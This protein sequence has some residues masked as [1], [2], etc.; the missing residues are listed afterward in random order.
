MMLLFVITKLNLGELTPTTLYL[1]M[2]DHSLTYPQGILE[3]VH[4]KVDKFIFSVDFV[5]LEMEE[6]RE[7]LIILGMPFLATRQAL[8]N[9]KNGELTLRVGEEEVKFNL[10]KTVRFVNDDKKTCMRVDSLNPSIG[11]VLRDMVKWNALEKSLT[12]SL[13]MADLEFEYASTV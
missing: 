4:V 6:D 2:V 10:T 13:S 12:K 1:Q 5:V 3:D 11:E 9:V 7:V 8:K